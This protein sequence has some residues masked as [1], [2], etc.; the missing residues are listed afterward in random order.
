MVQWLN[1]EVLN[2]CLSMD[3]FGYVLVSFMLIHILSECLFYVEAQFVQ[4]KC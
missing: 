3:L 2:K 4:K 1:I